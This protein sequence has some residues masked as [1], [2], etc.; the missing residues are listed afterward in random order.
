MQCQPDA[1]DRR[2]GARAHRGGGRD[3]PRGAPE[4]S[5]PAAAEGRRAGLSIK[6]P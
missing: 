6:I 2:G 5:A 1:F 3:R 4:G